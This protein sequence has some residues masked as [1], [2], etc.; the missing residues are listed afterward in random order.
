MQVSIKAVL[1]EEVSN[2]TKCVLWYWSMGVWGLTKYYTNHK[3]IHVTGTHKHIPKSISVSNILKCLSLL[4]GW[5][6]LIIHH[7]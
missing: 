2:S 6:L 5:V 7:S 4:L 1:D 3:T